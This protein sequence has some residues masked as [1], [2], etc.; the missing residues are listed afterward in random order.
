MDEKETALVDKDDRRAE[1]EA[2]G[3]HHI[4]FGGDRFGFLAS[5]GAFFVILMGGYSYVWA[6]SEVFK[7][8]WEYL[9]FLIPLLGIVVTIAAMLIEERNIFLTRICVARGKILERAMSI[10]DGKRV[11]TKGIYYL[12]SARPREPRL[13]GIPAR[14][15]IA[16][17][18]LYYTAFGVWLLLFG[19][20]IYKLAS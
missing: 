14:H 1:Y 10:T 13:L 5:F 16:I 4:F 7:K 11:A 9:L 20:G 15:T 19:Y 12:F 18:I 17:R 3:S 8:L 6:A 2:I